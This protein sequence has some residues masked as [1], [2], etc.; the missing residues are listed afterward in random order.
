MRGQWEVEPPKRN[1]GTPWVPDTEL[2]PKSAA[3]LVL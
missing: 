1:I 3:E 2:D